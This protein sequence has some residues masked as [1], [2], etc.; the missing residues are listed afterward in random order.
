[1]STPA[2]RT[3][4]KGVLAG[5]GQTDT[6][7]DPPGSLATDRPTTGGSMKST[8]PRMARFYKGGV[9]SFTAEPYGYPVKRWPPKRPSSQPGMDRRRPSDGSGLNKL[10]L[11]G[12]EVVNMW[13]S[14][15]LQPN[16]FSMSSTR[17]TSCIS[18]GLE[19]QPADR[20]LHRFGAKKV[21]IETSTDGTTW[22]PLAN[23]PE[24]NKRGDAG[25]HGQHHGQLRRCRGE[26]RQAD[27]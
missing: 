2:S 20:R 12:T 23:V 9:W 19:L 10:D 25:L 7:F 22:T 13:M 24:F 11:H 27:D 18:P 26:V 6:T 14:S 1:M 8:R 16:G 5:K 17:S 4:A 15:G 3:D 21:T